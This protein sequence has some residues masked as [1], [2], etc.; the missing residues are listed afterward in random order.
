MKTTKPTVS[1]AESL[2]ILIALLA[3]LGYLF[4]G[5]KFSAQF[6]ILFVFMLLLLYG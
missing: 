3:I 6:R 4:V 5:Q 2:G 1:I